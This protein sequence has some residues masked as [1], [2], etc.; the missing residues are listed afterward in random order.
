MMGEY[1]IY[2][3][4]KVIGGIY[5]DRLLLKPTEKI[6]QRI[7]SPVYELPYTGAKPMIKIENFE[8]EYL[9]ELLK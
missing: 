3:D 5:D 1:I 8:V 2:K 6:I 9:K 4:G 7:S